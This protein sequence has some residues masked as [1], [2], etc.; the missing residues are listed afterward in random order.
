MI[1]SFNTA[2]MDEPTFRRR[3]IQ[4]RA[5]YFTLYNHPKNHFCGLFHISPETMAADLGAPVKESME[6][7]AEMVKHGWIFIDSARELLWLPEMRKVLGTKKLS[8]AQRDA[9]AKYLTSLRYCPLVGK[10]AQ[11]MDIT[12]PEMEGG[13]L[14]PMDPG[15]SL[16]VS[17]SGAVSG[18][19]AVTDPD[20]KPFAGEPSLPLLSLVAV[21]PDA[22]DKKPGCPAKSDAVGASKPSRDVAN[23]MAIM[24][25]GELSVA[26]IRVN[27]RAE[28]LKTLECNLREIRAR[29][30]ENVSVEDIRHVIQVCEARAKVS[31]DAAKYFDAVS[32]FRSRN[33]GMWLA[34]SVSEAGVETGRAGGV[35][36]PQRW[37][38][39][40]SGLLAKKTRIPQPGDSEVDDE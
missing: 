33:I 29:L 38:S 18:S 25:L 5:L 39:G 9:T 15:T 6:W 8:E 35:P 26:R 14:P 3:T 16:S 31:P 27:S 40:S 12:L 32:P 4:A 20:S 10:V 30:L 1:R 11:S 28:P 13:T 22:Q 34:K 23:R 7:L 24:L 37:D 17:D 36:Q 21:G 19:G 2:I